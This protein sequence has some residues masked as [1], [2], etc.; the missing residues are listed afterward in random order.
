M[1]NA[2]QLYKIN[3]PNI[4]HKD[5][6]REVAMSYLKSFQNKAKAPWRKPSNLPGQSNIQYDQ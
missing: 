4:R 5:F 6:K 1:Q 2:W 3:A